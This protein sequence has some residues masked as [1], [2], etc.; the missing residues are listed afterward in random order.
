MRNNILFSTRA[1]GQLKARGH[2]LEKNRTTLA[3]HDSAFH[4]LCVPFV[5]VHCR[6]GLS[7]KD[8]ETPVGQP[9]PNNDGINHEEGL[10][11]SIMASPSSRCYSF[12]FYGRS[13]SKASARPFAVLRETAFS[14]PTI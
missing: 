2:F 10:T 14:P 9:S 12:L 6:R 13:I 4:F 5:A 11:M 8:P 7:G 3:G 1:H